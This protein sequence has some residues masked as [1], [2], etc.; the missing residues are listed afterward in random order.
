MVINTVQDIISAY[1]N[2]FIVYWMNKGYRVFIE[3]DK[4]YSCFRSNGSIAK[5]TDD[6]IKQCFTVKAFKK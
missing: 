3:N 6:E 1:N 5:L 2:G 4:A